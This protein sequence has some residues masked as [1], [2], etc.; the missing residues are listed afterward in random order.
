[1]ERLLETS[2]EERPKVN[3]C[4]LQFFNGGVVDMTVECG[5]IDEI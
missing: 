1:M 5:I 3:A 4:G 2:K